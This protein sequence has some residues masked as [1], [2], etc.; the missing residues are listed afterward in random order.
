MCSAS[1]LCHRVLSFFVGPLCS[2]SSELSR[3]HIFVGPLCAPYLFLCLCALIMLCIFALII[4][5]DAPLRTHNLCCAVASSLHLCHRTLI[6]FVDPMRAHHLRCVDGRTHQFIVAAELAYHLIAAY[7][8]VHLM[9]AI[10]ANIIFALLFL[11]AI[12]RAQVWLV[13]LQARINLR[14]G[15]SPLHFAMGSLLFQLASLPRA[16]CHFSWL[17]CHGFFAVQLVSLPW[18]HCCFNWL[19]CHRPIAISV[20]FIATGSLPFQLASL[21]R[22]HCRFHWLHCNGFITISIVF[23]A[24]SSLPFHWFHCLFLGTLPFQ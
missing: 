8:P 15:L 2:T 18:A 11:L 4:F 23:I 16:H 3:A 14:C 24:T 7:G 17:H 13:H 1:L 6:I 12:F 20:G 9:C 5:I 21:P 22:V 10:C 19:H